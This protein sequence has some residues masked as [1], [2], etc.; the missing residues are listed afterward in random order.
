MK[1]GGVDE[2]TRKILQIINQAVEAVGQILVAEQE[3]QR[4]DGLCLA[5]H[6]VSVQ[7]LFEGLW[8]DSQPNVK[9]RKSLKIDVNHVKKRKNKVCITNNS[10]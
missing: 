2:R 5:T 7:F 3:V 6:A 10:K 8:P 9:K 4:G 1:S